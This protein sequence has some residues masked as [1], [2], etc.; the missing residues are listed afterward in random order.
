M[1]TERPHVHP[2]S[3]P[4]RGFPYQPTVS[5]RTG[6]SDLP[7][8]E[9]VGDVLKDGYFAF[10]I[11][12]PDGQTRVTP[13]ASKPSIKACSPAPMRVSYGVI[14]SQILAI[15]RRVLDEYDGDI[16]CDSEVLMSFSNAHLRSICSTSF[17][18]T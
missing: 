2:D 5:P 1:N 14:A 9:N 4:L 16:P 17:V 3:S 8:D 11:D 15:A 6:T 7:T 18:L 13:S 10:T 12:R